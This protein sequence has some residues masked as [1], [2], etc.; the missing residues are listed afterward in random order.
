MKLVQEQKATTSAKGSKSKK[1]T[2]AD[3]QPKQRAG[4]EVEFVFK[5]RAWTP[6]K[7]SIDAVA[8][9][10]LKEMTKRLKDRAS[11]S[12]N[13]LTTTKTSLRWST[14]FFPRDQE[15]PDPWSQRVDRVHAGGGESR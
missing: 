7:S 6:Y 2:A 1:A 14:L 13:R 11:C 9:C 15:Q 8:G 10:V 4:A 3:D 12:I 5:M